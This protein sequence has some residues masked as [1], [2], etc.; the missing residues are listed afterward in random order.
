MGSP[1][2]AETIDYFCGGVN[3]SDNSRLNKILIALIVVQVVDI[4]MQ[5]AQLVLKLGG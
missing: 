2:L 3:M 4:V 5:V 1:A